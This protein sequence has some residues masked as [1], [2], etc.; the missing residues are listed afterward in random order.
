MAASQPAAADRG[1][2]TIKLADGLIIRRSSETLRPKLIEPHG[3]CSRIGF[4]SSCRSALTGFG[5]GAFKCHEPWIKPGRW[6]L[7]STFACAI[8]QSPLETSRQAA[9]DAAARKSGAIMVDGRMPANTMLRVEKHMSAASKYSA[10]SRVPR[11]SKRL[12]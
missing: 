1:N 12:K 10:D 6:I 11:L 4:V 7:A 2:P 5:S 3:A 8:R 9:L